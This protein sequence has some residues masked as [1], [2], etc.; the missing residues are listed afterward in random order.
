MFEPCARRSSFE[1]ACRIH[2]MPDVSI[3]TREN[4]PLLVTG[5]ITL[6]DPDGNAFDIA[7]KET[8]ALCRCG[9]SKNKPFCDG[10]HKVCGFVGAER[11]VPKPAAP[12]Q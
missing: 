10:T 6:V 3:R 11:A 7:G 1:N 9:Q 5:P 12:P 4:G 8:V 2:D